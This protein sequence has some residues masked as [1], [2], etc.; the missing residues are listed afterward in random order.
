MIR[1]GVAH[2]IAEV[3][4]WLPVL[5]NPTS[6]VLRNWELRSGKIYPGTK[7]ECICTYFGHSK[8]ATGPSISENF[9]AG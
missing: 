2:P 6:A 8:A 4:P 3:P 1:L 9:P 5:S 7:Q